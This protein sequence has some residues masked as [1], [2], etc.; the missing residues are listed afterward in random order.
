MKYYRI[1][2]V[3]DVA[4]VQEKA[5]NGSR[6]RITLNHIGNLYHALIT[7]DSYSEV[8]DD[9]SN[10]RLTEISAAEFARVFTT[11]TTKIVEETEALIKAD[12][13]S[14]IS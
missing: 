5:S 2:D 14:S 10:S 3:H 8:E 1:D 12:C 9:Y 6:R 13:L 7:S 11:L 4:E